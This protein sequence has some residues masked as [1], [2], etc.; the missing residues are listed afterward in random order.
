LKILIVDDEKY[1]RELLSEV[2]Q[3]HSHECETAGDGEE[4]LV[5]LE[6]E[7]FDVVITDAMM[8]RMD[9]FTLLKNIK[10]TYPETA[11]VV[12]TGYSIAY[13]ARDAM[14]IGAEEYLAKPFHTEEIL[15]VVDKAYRLKGGGDAAGRKNLTTA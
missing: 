12:I 6:Q 5:K 3:S 8:P 13:S 11:V 1:L 15:S 14:A 2:L 7:R 10:K 9:G 4:A